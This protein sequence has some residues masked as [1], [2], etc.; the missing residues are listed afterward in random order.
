MLAVTALLRRR[1]AVHR[2]DREQ[3]LRLRLAVEPVLEVGADDR[4]GSLRP[5]RQRA[6]AAVFERVHLLLDD[7]RARARRAREELGVLE[8][9]RLDAAVTGERAE[10]LDLAP[11]RCQSGCSAG[12]TSCVPRGASYLGLTRRAARRGTGWRRARRRVSFPDRGP[13]R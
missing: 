13:N 8:D 10:A 2:R 5:K 1:V 12:R 9:G 11:T 3:L 4:R 6:T 7:I